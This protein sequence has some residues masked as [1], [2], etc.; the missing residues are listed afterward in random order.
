MPQH[1]PTL[2]YGAGAHPQAGRHRADVVLEG[3]GVKGIAL[4]GALS[5]LEDAGFSFP[6]IAGTSAGAIVGALL[7][8]GCS[9]T[10]LREVLE[11]TDHRRFAD[12]SWLDRLPGGK[13]V[14]LLTES[15]VYEGEFL[16]TYLEELLGERGRTFGDLALPEDPRGSLLP[17]QRYRLVVNVSDVSLG[18]LVRFPWDYERLYGLDPATQSVADAVRASMSIPFFFEPA[19]IEHGRGPAPGRR[20]HSVLVDGGMLSNF[21]VDIFDT[22]AG[23]TPRW[24]TFGIKLSSRPGAIGATFP[25]DVQGPAELAKAMLGTMTSFRDAMHVDD[26]AVQARTIFVDT[27][28][29]RSTDFDLDAATR[30]AL[31]ASGRRAAKEFLATW[32]F[33]QYVERH[34]TAGVPSA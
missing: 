24:P 34:R 10:E 23:R 11:R 27:L 22:P 16:R 21:P 17:H 32:D 30:D 29:V 31:F 6:R 3:G 19:R 12:E 13:V 15:G 20:A 8:A 25:K 14:S 7:A 5:A 4:V 9:T 33:A 1:L 18:R 28:G 2:T 26:P